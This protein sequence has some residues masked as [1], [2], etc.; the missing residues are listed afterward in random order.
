M[1]FAPTK[2]AAAP[3]HVQGQCC[4]DPIFGHLC[5]ALACQPRKK[6]LVPKCFTASTRLVRACPVTALWSRFVLL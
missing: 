6:R 1:W 3:S 2:D 5:L 4:F